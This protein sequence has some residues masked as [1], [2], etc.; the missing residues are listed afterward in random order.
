MCAALQQRVPT[1]SK[2][3]QDNNP[4]SP[5]E[6]DFVK[7]LAL[8]G[9]DADHIR[10]ALAEKFSVKQKLKTVEAEL[11]RIG[12]LNGRGRH[13]NE[14]SGLSGMIGA[15]SNFSS[16]ADTRIKTPYSP[17]EINFIRIH[18][19]DGKSPEEICAALVQKFSLRREVSEVAEAIAG[20]ASGY[21]HETQYPGSKKKKSSVTKSGLAL[22]HKKAARGDDITVSQPARRTPKK[23]KID[24][25]PVSAVNLEQGKSYVHISFGAVVCVDVKTYNSNGVSSKIARLV[26]VY[27]GQSPIKLQIPVS[28]KPNDKIREPASQK[29]MQEVLY[30]LEH[31]LSSFKDIPNQ[32]KRLKKFYDEKLNSPDIAV[33]TDLLCLLYGRSKIKAEQSATTFE[34]G[35]KAI[36]NIA[37]EYALV[38]E[39][40]YYEAV[41]LVNKALGIAQTDFA[42]AISATQPP[43]PSS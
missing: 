31:G 29:T 13:G 15:A 16:A 3:K 40:K 26:Q 8:D 6:R 17:P 22:K 5:P 9:K 20:I 39:I 33:V 1:M 35:Q 42:P 2:N 36:A 7:K 25:K 34:Y 32:N 14:K 18:M 23:I 4:L 24:F 10:D 21:Y 37:S 43:R 19:A 11:E 30:K 28:S 38:M 12:F 27:G 41:G